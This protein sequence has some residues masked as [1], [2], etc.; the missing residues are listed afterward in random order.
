MRP[1]TI[2][3]KA[4]IRAYL[5]KHSDEPIL[6]WRAALATN[7]GTTAARELMIELETEGLATS[8]PVDTERPSTAEGE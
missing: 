5:R 2:A 7:I 4:A 8:E 6:P 3:A 1:K